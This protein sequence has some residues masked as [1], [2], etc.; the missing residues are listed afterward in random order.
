MLD[1]ILKKKKKHLWGFLSFNYILFNYISLS[2]T[3]PAWIFS[4]LVQ[5]GLYFQISVLLEEKCLL[6]F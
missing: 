4:L 2:L 6:L 5:S 3:L 1:Y